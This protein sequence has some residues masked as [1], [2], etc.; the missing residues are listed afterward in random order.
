MSGNTFMSG[1]NREVLKNSNKRYSLLVPI[2]YFLSICIH[3]FQNKPQTSAWAPSVVPVFWAACILVSEMLALSGVR[4]LQHPLLATGAAAPKQHQHCVFN[5]GKSPLPRPLLWLANSVNA[6]GRCFG[7]QVDAV[8]WKAH[9][10]LCT[11]LLQA[12]RC[13]LF[14]LSLISLLASGHFLLNRKVSL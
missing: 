2:T 10:L 11:F 12:L 6:W 13:Y 1:N 4:G 14:L 5:L 9:F 8:S 3:V 7:P